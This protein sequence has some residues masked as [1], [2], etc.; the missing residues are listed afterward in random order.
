VDLEYDIFEALP[1][2]TVRWRACARS[3]R[4][5]HSTLGDLGK[6]SSNQFFAMHLPTNEIVARVNHESDRSGPA[7][8]DKNVP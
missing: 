3:L 5:V 7:R 2:G 4:N 6:Q 8:A 1:D